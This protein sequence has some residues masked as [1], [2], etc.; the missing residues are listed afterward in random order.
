[1][2][3][4]YWKDRSILITGG[5]CFIAASL[6]GRLIALQARVHIIVR[7]TSS[8]WRLENYVGRV[9]VH[10]GDMTDFSGLSEIFAKATPDVVFHLATAKGKDT[11]TREF[12]NTSI[13]GATNLIEILMQ[14]RPGSKLIVAGSS[15]EYA[16]S[17]FALSESH[18]INPVTLHG[19][20]KA[21]A[22]LLY[23]HAARTHKLWIKQLRLFHVYGPWESPHR[24]LPTALHSALNGKTIPLT[25]G[26]SRRDWIFVEDVVDAM[27]LACSTDTDHNIF[28]IGSGVEYTN[29]EVLAIIQQLTG[30]DLHWQHDALPQRATDSTHRFADIS[31]AKEALNWS[32]GFSLVDGIASTLNWLNQNPGAFLH[33]T[34]APPTVF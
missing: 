10:T 4:N 23:S 34:E 32:P 19:T 2:S 20:A 17:D 29:A 5:S 3:N 12:I 13:E 26:G 18:P 8:M 24:F 7:P 31:R 14:G 9:G 15:T 30:Q 25:P 1:L 22:G 33:L 6:I 16:P 21:A 11:Q 28:N 27:L